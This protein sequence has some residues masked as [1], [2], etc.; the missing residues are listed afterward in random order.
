[1]LLNN[2]QLSDGVSSELHSN[3]KM[4][5]KKKNLDILL[6]IRLIFFIWL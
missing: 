5:R 3:I 6:V 2:K 4:K 1:M